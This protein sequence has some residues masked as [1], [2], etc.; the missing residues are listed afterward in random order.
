[1]TWLRLGPRS[2]GWLRAVG[3]HTQEDLEAIGAVEA[4][5]RLNATFPDQVNLDLLY[6]LHGVLHGCCWSTLT[7]EVKETLRKE[8][9][10]A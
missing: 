2:H 10:A 1:M 9:G 3:I 7:H 5:R 6:A 4:W 8:V